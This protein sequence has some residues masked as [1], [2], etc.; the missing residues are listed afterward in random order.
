M[1]HSYEEYAQWLK[2]RVAALKAEKDLSWPEIAN[3]MSTHN[4]TITSGSLMSKHSRGSFTAVE[5]IALLK[6]LE[7]TS[8][9]LPESET[10][11]T[12]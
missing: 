11:P 12:S 8:L 3:R 7:V 10:V 6:A 5:L 4:V 9:E 1:K 2:R